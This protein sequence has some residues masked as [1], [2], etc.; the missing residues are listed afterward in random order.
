MTIFHE[1]GEMLMIKTAIKCIFF[2]MISSTFFPNFVLVL[3]KISDKSNIKSSLVWVMA[4][5]LLWSQ[6][7]ILTNDDLHFNLTP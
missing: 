2:L 1:T 3:F 4:W 7:I 6:A 5:H